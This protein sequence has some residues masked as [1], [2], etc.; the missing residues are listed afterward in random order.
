M[1]YV[2]VSFRKKN[3]E[4]DNE[5]LIAFLANAGFESFENTETAIEAFMPANIFSKNIVLDIPFVKKHGFA[6]DMKI[7]HIE[8]QNWNAFWESNYPPV[9]IADKIYIYAPFHQLIPG[10]KYQIIIKP[11]MS[12]GTAHHE[13]TAMM[14][15]LMLKENFTEKTVLDMGSGTAVLAILASMKGA[16]ETDA[17]DNDEWAYNNALENIKLNNIKNINPV[18]GDASTL[19]QHKKYDIILANINKNILLHDMP[20][21][22]QTLTENGKIFFSGFYLTDLDDLKTKANELKLSYQYHIEKNKWVAA[23]FVKQ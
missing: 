11:K 9:S 8:E 13:T 15:T 19:T 3:T 4:T 1:N 21:Y 16:F 12:F 20:F 7:E 5:I 17:I 22:E 6:R 23:C 2:R 14:M 18:L 10:Y